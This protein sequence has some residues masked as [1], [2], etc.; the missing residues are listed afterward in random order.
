E[1][2]VFQSAEAEIRVFEYNG[3]LHLAAHDAKGFIGG[4]SLRSLSQRDMELFVRG[5]GS[6][7]DEV[8]R[9][10]VCGRKMP[11]LPGSVVPVVAEPV[12]EY[13]WCM[14]YVH[15]KD[16]RKFGTGR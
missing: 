12:K 10:R 8:K 6:R 15:G 1:D 7:A 16:L 9:I 3:L 13:P 4:T 2:L 14:E 11:A 5:L